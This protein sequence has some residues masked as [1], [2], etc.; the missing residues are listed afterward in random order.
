LAI[1][2]STITPQAEAAWEQEERDRIHR[3]AQ[4]QFDREVKAQASL[5]GQRLAADEE[6]SAER[7]A[8][9]RLRAKVLAEAEAGHEAQRVG[10]SSVWGE[11]APNPTLPKCCTQ[12]HK[13]GWA[14]LVS[15]SALVA[16]S[17]P[18]RW[19]TSARRWGRRVES[20]GGRGYSTQLVKRGR[21]HHTN[22]RLPS[23]T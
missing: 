12:A 22:S 5:Q 23:G 8:A 2:L 11:T 15:T 14:L 19:R 17:N 4:E 21:R 16:L 6:A 18:R 1:S 7:L 10:A 13:C 9:E 3:V 20:K